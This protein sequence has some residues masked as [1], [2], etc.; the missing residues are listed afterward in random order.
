MAEGPIGTNNKEKKMKINRLLMVL[1]TILSIAVFFG[2]AKAS[3][4]VATFADPSNNSSN[5]LFNVDF[6]TNTISGGWD[7]SKTG[8]T[9]QFSYNGHTYS[10]AWFKLMSV[11]GAP[12]LS[13]TSKTTLPWGTVGTVGPGSVLF[14]KNNTS[15]NPLFVVGFDGGVVSMSNFGANMLTANTVTFSGSEITGSLSQQEFS[16]SF[17]NVVP[18]AQDNGFTST[19]S[20]TSSAVP[21]PATIGL[22]CLGVLKL[23]IR[24]RNKK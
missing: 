12:T 19:A 21:E 24:K 3:F 20:F 16:F 15:T 18:L 22:L 10:D 8:L 14:Y 2:E 1:L 4:T 17:A 23:V 13:I 7:D 6:T 11:S 9:L 5:P